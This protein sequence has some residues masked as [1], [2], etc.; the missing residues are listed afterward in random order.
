MNLKSND[1]WVI[2]YLLFLW[3]QMWLRTR[4][5][6]FYVQTFFISIFQ[7]WHLLSLHEDFSLLREKAFDQDNQTNRKHDTVANILII[8]NNNCPCS[9]I[10]IVFSAPVSLPVCCWGTICPKCRKLISTFVFF[11]KYSKPCYEILLGTNNYIF[12]LTIINLRITAQSRSNLPLGKL[13]QHIIYNCKKVA[14]VS[15]LKADSNI[16]RLSIFEFDLKLLGYKTDWKKQQNYANRSVFI[17]QG[18]A[19]LW[20]K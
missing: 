13:L 17:V 20:Q 6:N 4:K 15:I 1:N 16:L 7:P 5:S 8:G 14:I 11:N 10:N 19:S 2:K 18:R 12:N 3:K 9:C